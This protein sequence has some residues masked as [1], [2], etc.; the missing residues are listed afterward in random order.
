[1]DPQKTIAKHYQDWTQEQ[2]KG[3]FQSQQTPKLW[4]LLIK[5]MGHF[6]SYQGTQKKNCKELTQP[7]LFLQ[8]ASIVTQKHLNLR[9]IFVSV[10]ILERILPKISSWCKSLDTQSRSSSRQRIRP[11]L[12]LH[13]ALLPDSGELLKIPL[14]TV[15]CIFLLILVESYAALPR[16]WLFFHKIDAISRVSISLEHIKENA[17]NI[18]SIVPSLFKYPPNTKHE[19]LCGNYIT[20]KVE[21]EHAKSEGGTVLGLHVTLAFSEAIYEDL[22]PQ[23]IK[24]QHQTEQGFKYSEALN[25]FYYAWNYMKEAS[26]CDKPSFLGKASNYSETSVADPA[27]KSVEQEQLLPAFYRNLLPLAESVA[28]A[29]KDQQLL[30]YIFSKKSFAQDIRTFCLLENGSVI[31]VHEDTREKHIIDDTYKELVEERQKFARETDKG[32]LEQA[33]KSKESLEKVIR[34]MPI[35]KTFFWL[36]VIFGI[37]TLTSVI[38]ATSQYI[39]YKDLFH[40]LQSEMGAFYYVPVQYVSL[41]EAVRYLVQAMSVNE[42]FYLSTNPPYR[43]ILSFANTFPKTHSMAQLH[44]ITKQEIYRCINTL[45]AEIIKSEGST[46]EAFLEKFFPATCDYVYFGSNVTIKNLTYVLALQEVQFF[47]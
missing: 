31:E 45:K 3:Q 33:L 9:A 17:I 24:L 2:M 40:I 26:P 1:M 34:S 12:L 27:N 5:S 13:I 6:A 22:S 44:D 18:E 21:W 43:N 30:K 11:I 15:L 35:P 7:G 19:V 47:L 37:S 32:M 8:F 25:K 41:M 4:A 38:I 10:A 46:S 29:T 14:S 28:E 20:V 39:I 16:V 42:Y 23:P 36:V